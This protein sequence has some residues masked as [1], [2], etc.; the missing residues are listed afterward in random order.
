MV[1]P[2]YKEISHKNQVCDETPTIFL[3]ISHPNYLTE[4]KLFL[5]GAKEYS[6]LLER[7]WYASSKEGDCSCSPTKTY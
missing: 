6:G 1:F 5:S 4:V 2:L 3:V 7:T